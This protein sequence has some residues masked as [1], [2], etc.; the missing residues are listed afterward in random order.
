MNCK[1]SNG[2]CNKHKYKQVNNFTI[3]FIYCYHRYQ[4]DY[5]EDSGQAHY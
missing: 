5:E 2:A 1:P 3:A 4:G